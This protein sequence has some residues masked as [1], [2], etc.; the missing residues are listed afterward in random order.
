M[1]RAVP[2]VTSRREFLEET[3]RIAAAS[4]LAGVAMPHV[5]AAENN[6]IQ[7]ALIGCGGRGT[8]AAANALSVQ[9][10]PDQAGGHGRR[11]RQPARAAATATCKK[12]FGDQ[13]DVPQDR[14][15]IGFDAYRRRWTA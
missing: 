8:G 2:G 11:L 7:V 4:A 15:F 10:R 3:G 13:V 9:Q 6:T 1:K 14:K 5:H 12:Q